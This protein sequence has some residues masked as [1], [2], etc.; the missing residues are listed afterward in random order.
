MPTSSE[1]MD[2]FLADRLDGYIGETMRLC[3]Q[4]SVSATGEGVRECAQLV[5]EM[6]AQRGLAVQTFET[7][8]QPIVV[9]HAPG[10]SSRRLLFYN[11]YDVQPPEPLDLW[12]TPPF[13]PAIR[14]GKVYARG[15]ADDKGEFVA[16]LAALDA[17]RAAH[18]G[19]L[20]CGVVFVVE[21]EEEVSSP[22]IAQFVQDHLELLAADGALWEGGGIDPDGR[23]STVLGFRGIIALELSVTTLRRDAHSGAAHIL[24]NAAWRLLRALES[25]KG[26]DE[27]I[28]IPGFYD[29]VRPPSP[30]DLDL[31]ARQP[32]QEAHYR[33]TYGVQHFVGGRR[34]QA[35]AAAVFEP[36]CN[37]QGITTGYQGAGAKTVIPAVA[38]AK[39][40]FR[41]VP[42]QD[43]AEVLAL[44]QEHL[45]AQGFD[46]VTVTPYGMMWPFKATADDPLVRLTLRA[47]AEVYGVEP[48]PP[49]PLGGGSSPAYAFAGPLGNIPVVHAGVGYP[50][51]NAHAPDENIR[52]AD[53][54]NGARHI[55]RLLDEFAAL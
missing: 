16:R 40:D 30:H 22:H 47:A 10:A 51:A 11:H 21:G 36:T 26:P 9:A 17:V 18:G 37:I 32:D 50:N 43:P 55:A 48:R 19:D 42:D 3:A 8:G 20:P 35:L 28:R 39:L 31:L 46:D 41:L 34:G 27:R 45:H 7:P 15:V 12:T 29:R 4:P 24:P 53:F 6:L 13:A 25:I 38:S 5:A 44:L 54:L 52:I 23:P 33:E 14:D 49:M 1:R 2:Q